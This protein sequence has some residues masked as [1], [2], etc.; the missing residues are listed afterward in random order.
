MSGKLRNEIR[1]VLDTLNRSVD[2][3][4]TALARAADMDPRD[5]DR[6]GKAWQRWVNRYA[7]EIE[8]TGL[9]EDGE[10]LR[11]R[12][13]LSMAKSNPD[14]WTPEVVYWGRIAWHKSGRPMHRVPAKVAFEAPDG[15]TV[16]KNAER[17]AWRSTE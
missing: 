15:R 3:A 13:V 4:T 16:R 14:E 2:A 9:R 12:T 7:A 8:E 5:L 11:I 17:L 10:Q 1:D 6:K